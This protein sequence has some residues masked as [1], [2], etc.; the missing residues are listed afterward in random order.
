MIETGYQREFSGAVEAAASTGGQIMPPIM[1][2]AAFIMTEYVGVNYGTVA[3][4]AVIPAILYFTGIF[5]NVH[6][7]ALKNGLMGLDKEHRQD[8]KKLF[9]EGWYMLFPVVLIFGLL[10]GGSS[11]MKAAMYGIIGCIAIWIINII[12]REEV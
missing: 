9:K 5:T 6:F 7:E 3:L 8:A 2:A 10:I 11:A 4:A 12:K 1:G